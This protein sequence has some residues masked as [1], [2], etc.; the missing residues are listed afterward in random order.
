M[1][2][3]C[4]RIVPG[5]GTEVVVGQWPFLPVPGGGGMSLLPVTM[6]PIPWCIW[7]HLPPPHRYYRM[8]DACENIS[9]AHFATR[10]V[11]ISKQIKNNNSVYNISDIRPIRTQQCVIA[12]WFKKETKKHNTLPNVNKR[13]NKQVVTQMIS[14][15]YML[16]EN[17]DP[18][19]MYR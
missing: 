17:E 15:L 10:A 14:W 19:V 6:W 4:L 18:N 2:T 8:T 5:W 12:K 1:R 16:S 9:F 3:A 13:V 7:C 11:N